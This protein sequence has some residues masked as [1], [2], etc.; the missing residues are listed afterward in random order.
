MDMK[1]FEDYAY[2]YN[3]FY[4]NKDYSNEALYIH[5]LIQNYNKGTRNILD[6]GCGT[7]K[8]DLELSKLRYKVHGIDLSSTMIEQAL[9]NEDGNK[10][11]FKVDDI[12]EYRDDIKYDAVISLFHVM[13]YQ[14]TNEDLERAF[15]TAYE[16]LNVGGI[17]IFDCWYGPGVLTDPPV[18]RIKRVENEKYYIIRLAEPKTDTVNNVVDVNYDVLITDKVSGVTKNIKEIHRMRYLFKPEIEYI[19]KKVGF[20]L[21]DCFEFGKT[22]M[23]TNDSWYGCFVGVK[24]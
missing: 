4:E 15:K 21:L 8:H 23:L 2:Y 7:G 19:M 14:C 3:L 17:F 5:K 1:V 9:R 11:S 13:S 18:V 20:K 24:I 16:A 12:R 10:L 22:E 6:L